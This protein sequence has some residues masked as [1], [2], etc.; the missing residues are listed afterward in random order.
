MKKS[1]DFFGTVPFRY[2]ALKAKAE[3]KNSKDENEIYEA[4]EYKTDD[5][6]LLE[7]LL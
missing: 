1:K 3:T 4:Q 6:E 5:K 7:W 2:T